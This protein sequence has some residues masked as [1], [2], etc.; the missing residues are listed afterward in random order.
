MARYFLHL[1]DRGSR[2]IDKEGVE[3]PDMVAA[4]AKSLHA[5]RAIMASDVQDGRLDLDGRI[6]VHNVDQESVMRTPFGAAAKLSG[7]DQ[8]QHRV[9]Q[10]ILRV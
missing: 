9:G 6:D 2:I 4:R 7:I 8:R 5:A 3:L 1:Y 10:H